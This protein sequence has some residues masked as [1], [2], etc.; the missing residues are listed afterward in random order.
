MAEGAGLA[1][2]IA[3]V[4]PQ[5]RRRLHPVWADLNAAGV[6]AMWQ[7]NS[8]ADPHVSLSALSRQNIEWLI[9]AF[10]TPP[11]RALHA[12]NGELSAWGV[13]SPEFLNWR[14]LA[15][16]SKILV[17]ETDASKLHG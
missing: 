15:S 17:I 9:T 5:A 8:S 4:Y 1:S 12:Q 13:R 3:E 7:K 16:D 2:H 14:T 6:Y 10:E 11:C